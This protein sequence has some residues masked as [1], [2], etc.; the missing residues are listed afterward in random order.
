MYMYMCMCVYPCGESEDNLRF[1]G[2]APPFK[3]GPLSHWSGITNWAKRLDC[4]AHNPPESTPF[5]PT[6]LPAT[7]IHLHA[8]FVCLLAF[9]VGFKDQTQILVISR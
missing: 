5:A 6:R 9:S 1:P 4:Q 8:Q 2:T 7:S 3:T